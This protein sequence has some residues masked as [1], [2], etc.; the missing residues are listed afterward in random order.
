MKENVTRSASAVAINVIRNVAQIVT[1]PVISFVVKSSHVECTNA[2]KYV[3]QDFVLSVGEQ[4]LT[5]SPAT[6]EILFCILQ[7]LAV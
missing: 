2:K 6:V 7:L 5:N 4:G 1:M 3:T